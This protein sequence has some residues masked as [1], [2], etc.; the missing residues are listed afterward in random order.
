MIENVLHL[1]ASHRSTT[2]IRYKGD[3][4]RCPCCNAA[5]WRP[6]RICRCGV[7]CPSEKSYTQ[8]RPRKK[9]PAQLPVDRIEYEPQHDPDNWPTIDELDDSLPWIE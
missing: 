4:T 8:P 5:G 9:A 6:G 7:A 3:S 2:E 1:P